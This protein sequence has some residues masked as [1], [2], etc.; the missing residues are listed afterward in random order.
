MTMLPNIV[1]IARREFT[2]R[3]RTRSYLVGTVLILLGVV[4]IAFVPVVFGYFDRTDSQRIAVWVDAGVDGDPAATLG[5]L[6]N[7]AQ[8]GQDPQAPAEFE[9]V[10]VPDIGAARGDMERGEYVA[11]LG[12]ERPEAG[13]LRFR[14]YTNQSSAGRTAQLVRQ[15]SQTLTIG[16]RLGRLGISPGDQAALFAPPDYGVVTPDPSPGEAELGAAYLLGFSMT[17]L[18]FMLILLYGTW[19]AMSVVEEKSSRVMEV[20]LNAAT[21]FQLLTGKVLGV[22]AIALTQYA[23]IITVGIVA[24]LAQGPIAALV[25]GE[26]ADGVTLPQGL[27]VQMLLLLGVYGVLGFLL[28]AVLFAAAGS[29]VSRQEDVNQAVMPMTLLSSAGYFVGVYA[30]TGFLDMQAGWMT[31]LAQVPFLSPFI[32]LSRVSAGQAAAWEVGLSVILLIVSIVVA[33]WIAARIYAAGVLLYGQ[34]PGL[35]AILRMARSGM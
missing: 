27:T 5:A 35:R 22:G 31:V 2:V 21:P 14:L 26:P 28:Y 23:A 3:A 8:G 15:A 16:D 25:L 4:A 17:I 20:I 9:V 33:L 10:S 34:R 13:D 7:P 11:V 12:V 30:A 6:L 32:M 19:V 24:V 1:A 18:I 29:L